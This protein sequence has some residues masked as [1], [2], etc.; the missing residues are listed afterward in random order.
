MCTEAN[1][2]CAVSDIP[3]QKLADENREQFELIQHLVSRVDALEEALKAQ[4]EREAAAASKSLF[5]G[6]FGTRAL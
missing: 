6:F 5:G 4:R 3:A 1:A 2:S